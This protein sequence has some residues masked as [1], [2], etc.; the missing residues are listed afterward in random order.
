MV[1]PGANG[2]ENVTMNQPCILPPLADANLTCNH[3]LVIATLWA[4]VV[5]V[6]R[7]SEAY[8]YCLL[9]AHLCCGCVNQVWS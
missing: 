6:A 4:H 7:S 1:E 8:V 2:T 3:D 5:V 9:C